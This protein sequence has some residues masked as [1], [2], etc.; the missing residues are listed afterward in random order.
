[1]FA[2]LLLFAPAALAAAAVAWWIA[3][4]YAKREAARPS[5][6]AFAAAAAALLAALALYLSIGRPELADDPYAPRLAELQRRDPAAMPP[7]ELLAVLA[8]RARAAPGDARPHLYAGEILSGQGRDAEAARAFAAA[9]RRDPNSA[10]ALTGM[11]RVMVRL[12]EGA[13]GPAALDLFRRAAAIDPADPAPW[14]YQALAATQAGDARARTLWAEVLQR[15]PPDDPRRAMA[16]AMVN[17]PRAQTPQP[18]R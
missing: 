18:E 1:M 13:V 14:L 7:E 12:D 16:Q 6:A 9:L 3:R 5:R 10:P 8:A 4:A 11:G 2:S 15:L 17:A